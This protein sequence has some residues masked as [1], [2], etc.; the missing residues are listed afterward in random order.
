MV[1]NNAVDDTLTTENEFEKAQKIFQQGKKN[2]LLN[3]YEEAVDNIDEA[4]K[5]L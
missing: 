2:L 3:K 5:L 4:C 1:S